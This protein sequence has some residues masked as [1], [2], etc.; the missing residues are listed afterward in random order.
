MAKTSWR[1][2]VCGT[3][4]IPRVGLQ[5]HT[6][7]WMKF[8]KQKFL[9]WT[10]D[11]LEGKYQSANR[12]RDAGLLLCIGVHIAALCYAKSELPKS[13]QFPTGIIISVLVL[14]IDHKD[15]FFKVYILHLEYSFHHYL[16]R[17]ILNFSY[18]FHK[19]LLL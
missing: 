9:Q 7:E 13:M 3:L 8:R 16:L 14:L 18:F 19:K 11:S 15:N 6:W 10:Y 5:I 2:G 1:R 17:I 4:H 12:S